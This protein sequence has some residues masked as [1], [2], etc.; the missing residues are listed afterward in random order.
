[1]SVCLSLKR[2]QDTIP[3]F[4]NAVFPSKMDSEK[5]MQRSDYVIAVKR[6]LQAITA[7]SSQA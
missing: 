5:K 1:V 4:K 2:L 6:M 3:I 7:Q